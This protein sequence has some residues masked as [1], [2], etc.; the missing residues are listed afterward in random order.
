MEGL[1]PALPWEDRSTE[2]LVNDQTSSFGDAHDLMITVLNYQMFDFNESLLKRIA[3]D[4][5]VRPSHHEG[6]ER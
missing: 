2:D 6:D 3:V 5:V 4:S 1:R